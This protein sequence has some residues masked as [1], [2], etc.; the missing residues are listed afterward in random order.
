MPAIALDG[1]SLARKI[2]AELREEVAD[3]IENN[4]TIPTLAAVLVGEDPASEVYVRNKRRDCEEVGISSNLHRLPA[5]IIVWLRSAT[6]FRIEVW[7]ETDSARL[8]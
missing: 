2:R 5:D 7:K 6:L 3:F 4:V 1:K 8:L